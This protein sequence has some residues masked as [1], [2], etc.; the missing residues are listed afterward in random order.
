MSKLPKGIR[1]IYKSGQVVALEAL[2]AVVKGK[3]KRKYI[4]LAKFG[5]DEQKALQVVRDWQVDKQREVVKNRYAVI[6]VPDRMRL[7]ILEAQEVLEPWGVSVLQAVRVA[8]E[9]FKKS[10]VQTE[11]TLENAI[12]IYLKAKE[13]E[14]CKPRYLRAM[15]MELEALSKAFPGKKVSEISADM[16]EGFLTVRQIHPTTWNNW[17]RDLRTFFNFAAGPRHRWVAQNPAEQVTF[18]KVDLDDVEILEL[19]D[20]QKL[21]KAASNHET[22]N[23]AGKVDKGRQVPWLVLGLFG[24]LRRD[25]ADATCWEDID[26]DA[27]SLKVRA[28]KTTRSLRSRYLHMQPVMA[29]WL[30]L[31]KKESGRIGTG[32][33]ARRNDLQKLS[34][35]TGLDLS[36][37]LYRHSFGSYHYQAYK[38]IG[39]TMA[40]MGHTNAKTF[41]GYYNRSIPKLRALAYWEL[42]PEEVLK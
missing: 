35:A 4:G 13:L 30:K 18:K 20:V 15:T 33:S 24:G 2:A 9:Q 21:L 17:R 23:Y 38:D 25:E 36:K 1:R 12:R 14:N 27:N 31:Y 5:G 6:D 16:I 7:E 29:N 11:I 37:N 19:Q 28:T 32:T 40:E 3:K 26:W 41:A 10:R 39:E 8:I 22:P 42:Q 34:L